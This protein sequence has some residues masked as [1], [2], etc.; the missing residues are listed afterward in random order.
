MMKIFIQEFSLNNIKFPEFLDFFVSKNSE[1]SEKERSINNLRYDDFILS[2][3]FFQKIILK[4]ETNNPYGE[5]SFI[6]YEYFIN[7]EFYLVNH[8]SKYYLV[9]I[10]PSKFSKNFYSYFDNIVGL[11]LILKDKK[12][13]INHLLEFNLKD[14]NYKLVKAKFSSVALS[15]NS[16][17]TIEIISS[18]NAIEDFKNNF[19]E[20]Y[21]EINKIKILMHMK[22]YNNLDLEISRSGL[23]QS[24][25]LKSIHDNDILELLDLLF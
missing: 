22:K 24:T 5:K 12:I 23:I 7:Q 13:D 9:I 1:L 11:K 18:S 6:E 10:N 2:G 19:G 17:A 20:V 14:I 25:L 21:Y 15:K 8:S 3:N 4:E 16:K